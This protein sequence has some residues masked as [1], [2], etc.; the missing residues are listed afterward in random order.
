MLPVCLGYQVWTE[1]TLHIALNL[2][3]QQAASLF[4]ARSSAASRL[5]GL[6]VR[7]VVTSR[8]TAP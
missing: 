3:R 2:T 6:S 8:I 4:H 1:R 7:H 5:G